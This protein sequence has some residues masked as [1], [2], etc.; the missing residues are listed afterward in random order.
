MAVVGALS[1]VKVGQLYWLVN[2][3]RR[4]VDWWRIRVIKVIEKGSLFTEYAH[5]GCMRV[6]KWDRCEE[7]EA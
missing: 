3:R 7:E 2:A 4:P 5:R 6:K 1:L